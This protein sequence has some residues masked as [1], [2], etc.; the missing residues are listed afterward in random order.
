[1]K[2]NPEVGR[3]IATRLENTPHNKKG[4]LLAEYCAV[5]GWSKG[6]FWRVARRHGYEHGHKS[7][8]DKGVAKKVEKEKMLKAACVIERTRRKTGKVNMPTWNLLLHFKD[9]GIIEPEKMPSES[10]VNTYLR[11]MDISRSDL[12]SPDPRIHLRSLHPNHVHLIDASVCVM[13]DFKGRKKLVT[14]DMQMEFYKGKPG[15]WRDVKKVILRYICVDHTTGWFYVWY[16]YSLGED[17]QN[18]FDFTMRAWGIKEDPRV[19]P[20]HG[21]PAVLMVDKGSANIS[22]YFRN[23]M[24][25]LKVEL[26]VHTPGR[27]WISGGVETMHGYWERA[28]EGDLSLLKIEDLGEL[29]RRASDKCAY[30]N[31]MR[32]HSRHGMTRFEAYMMIKPGQLRNL[33]PRSVCQRLCYS[34]AEVVTVDAYKQIRYDTNCY[35]LHGYFRRGDKLYVRYNPDDY[36]NVEVNT[37]EDF[38]GEMVATTR[39]ERDAWGFPA[40][41]A[42]IGQTYKSHKYDATKRFKEDMKGIDIS[43]VVP[44]YQAEKLSKLVWMPKKGHDAIPTEEVK[45]PP[46]SAHDARKRLREGLGI[47]RFTTLQ[48]QWLEKRFLESVSEERFGEVMDEYR[49][50]FGIVEPEEAEEK[51]IAE[52]RG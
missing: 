5:L 27:P 52:G 17:F 1:M 48:S 29:N 11:E 50:R 8:A 38:R 49:R 32:E 19:F 41:A 36:P 2:V 16:Y 3:E 18:L 21:M 30:I 33:P 51:K 26:I 31:A 47:S 14:R 15:F 28:F 13:W 45:T 22:Q 40:N 6:T 20:S 34:N 46:M 37:Q 9:N 43:D 7:R 23:L 12:I 4:E 44:Q 25:N 42:I 39:I 35:L 10:T 24:K